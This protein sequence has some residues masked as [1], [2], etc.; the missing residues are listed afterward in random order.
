MVAC[1]ADQSNFDEA[2]NNVWF[3]VT[4]DNDACATSSAEP[5]FMN[6]WIR[7]RAPRLFGLFRAVVMDL[8]FYQEE[9]STGEFVPIYL[10]ATVREGATPENPLGDYLI[11]MYQNWA[12]ATDA[13]FFSRIEYN[14]FTTDLPDGS[15]AMILDLSYAAG[16]GD[17]S[18]ESSSVMATSVDP[19]TDSGFMISAYGGGDDG[20]SQFQY[21]SWNADYVYSPETTYVGCGDFGEE[22]GDTCFTRSNFNEY[23]WNYRVYNAATGDR[24]EGLGAVWGDYVEG[25][26]E[27]YV[28]CRR[29]DTG[30]TCCD[31]YAN[32]GDYET[33]NPD[34]VLPITFKTWT[35][36]GERPE[37]VLDTP[38]SPT[39][40]CPDYPGSFEADM[41]YDGVATT[42]DAPIDIGPFNVTSAIERNGASDP[43]DG[44]WINLRLHYD[45]DYLRFDYETYP[46]WDDS[47]GW[48]QD[49]PI[50]DGV[51]IDGYVFRCMDI[52]Q[53]FDA[54]DATNCAG[55]VAFPTAAINV[56]LVIPSL[57]AYPDD[58]PGAAP[59]T[60]EVTVFVGQDV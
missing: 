18:F 32:T 28:N 26:V 5:R 23:C 8:V 35:R 9:S 7:K 57:D 11:Q 53:V 4:V 43:G 54:A 60:E 16:Q 58:M 12:N 59:T 20:C 52:N 41:T 13:S 56:E 40:N 14:I 21:T 51:E 55:L 30:E 48:Y 19:A 1:W 45:Y 33:S 46:T 3:A 39:G 49:I 50:A 44:S 22:T 37:I 29:G 38:A 31:L 42:F 25:G 2:A 27:H 24:Y 36:D 34:A 17:E 6:F 15:R 47:R 10:T